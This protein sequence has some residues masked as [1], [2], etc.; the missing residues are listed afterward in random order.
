MAS[1]G[2]GGTKPL[3]RKITLFA[4]NASFRGKA[5]TPIRDRSVAISASFKTKPYA[6]NEKTNPAECVGKTKRADGSGLS[7]FFRYFFVQKSGKGKTF[8]TGR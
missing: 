3:L 5:I 6:I 8:L 7:K 1:C 2:K 4:E